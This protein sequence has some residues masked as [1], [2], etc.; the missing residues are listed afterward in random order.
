MMTTMDEIG[1][2]TSMGIPV[3]LPTATVIPPMKQMKNK[4]VQT[5][6]APSSVTQEKEESQKIMEN[7]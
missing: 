7:Q 1:A 5:N 6:N 3:M 4:K 2:A